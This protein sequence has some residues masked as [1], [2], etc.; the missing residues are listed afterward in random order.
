MS[1]A[2][3]YFS[4]IFIDVRNPLYICKHH[5]LAVMD[6]GDCRS[7]AGRHNSINLWVA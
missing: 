3:L 6:K 5:L 2:N 1:I 4:M 7:I